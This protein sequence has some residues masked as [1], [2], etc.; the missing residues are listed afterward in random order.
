MPAD[1]P[2]MRRT[3]V[4]ACVLGMIATVP[5]V[6]AHA[7][8]A[9]VRPHEPA[10][11]RRHA[12]LPTARQCHGCWLPELET[13]WQ[14]QLQGRIDTSLPVEMFDIDGFETSAAVVDV[15]HGRGAAA[16]CY[17]DVGSWERWRPDAGAFPERVLG[18]S[19]GWPGE[20]WLDIRRLAI[21]RPLMRDRLDVCAA[22]GFDGV[23]LD[24]VDGYR[25][26]TGF[27]LTARDQ[28]RYNAALANAAHAR[29]MSVALKNDLGQIDALL[30]YFDYAVNEQCHQYRECAKLRPF[31][32][33]GKAVFG[34][35]YALAPSAFCSQSNAA[36]FNF[37]AKDVDLRAYPRIA[38]RGE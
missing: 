34:V 4:L 30:P 24:L 36:N 1:T 8:S 12:V 38:C 13:S 25:H 6:S 10:R 14:W 26:R 17:V 5:R 33:A 35:E 15:I 28:L 11:A 19:D 32:A 27:S 2:R 9:A 21:L 23:E 31:V 37:L 3:A 29:G 22:K 7:A 16:V 20:R 18:R